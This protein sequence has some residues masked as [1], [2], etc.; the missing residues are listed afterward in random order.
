MWNID[1]QLERNV[2]LCHKNWA[3]WSRLFQTSRS[4][5]LPSHIHNDSKSFCILVS[6]IFG[7]WFSYFHLPLPLNFCLPFFLRTKA[8]Y[9]FKLSPSPPSCLIRLSMWIHSFLKSCSQSSPIFCFNWADYFLGCCMTIILGF[10]QKLG[11]WFRSP[12]S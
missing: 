8:A 6:F 11:Y 3:S 10:F 1:V 9:N 5:G 2:V 7:F 12:V 4:N